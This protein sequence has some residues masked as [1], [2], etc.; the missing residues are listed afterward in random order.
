MELGEGCLRFW[1]WR[2]L[3]E[4]KPCSLVSYEAV[5]HRSVFTDNYVSNN[6][7]TWVQ[8]PLHHGNKR[9]TSWTVQRKRRRCIYVADPGRAR[10]EVIYKH[11]SLMAATLLLTS[12]SCLSY[13]KYLRQFISEL[14]LPVW[15]AVRSIDQCDVCNGAYVQITLLLPGHI[16]SVIYQTCTSLLLHQQK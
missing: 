14:G 9:L 11:K 5:Q 1:W 2:D 8:A 12:L 13:Y 6:C 7:S 3:I 15:T 16:P 10:T 4:M